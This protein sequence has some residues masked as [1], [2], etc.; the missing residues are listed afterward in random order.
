M[1]NKVLPL[2]LIST[3][4]MSS[5]SSTYAH[6]TY[7]FNQLEKNRYIHYENGTKETAEQVSH[8][9]P[10]SLK[11][12]VNEEYINFKNP[13]E[14]NV[15]VFSS[16][17]RYS[18]YSSSS[19]ESRASSTTNDIFLSPK[20][21]N[22]KKTLQL[23]LVHELSHIHMRQYVGTWRSI[24]NIPTWFDEGL[25]VVTSKGG[26]AEKVS[27]TQAIE[28]INDGKHFI[29]VVDTGVFSHKY[30]HDYGL[31]PHMFYRQSG[32]FINYLK[33]VNPK[34]FSKSYIGLSDGENFGNV[35]VKYYGKT[36]HELWA[37]FLLSIK[38]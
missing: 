17:E 31:T 21:G 3:L 5:C 25:A 20:I 9:L 38:A 1:M 24:T 33:Q 27:E 12:V 29:P 7:D 23:L 14:I 22:N 4:I 26:G 30:A 32:M 2:L 19:I 15:Y 11:Q 34:A 16:K 10:Q 36:M 37:E 35:W 6:L 28:K 8:L 13:G 18:I